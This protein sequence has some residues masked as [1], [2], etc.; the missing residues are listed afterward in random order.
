MSRTAKQMK[1]DNVM[2][3]LD[4]LMRKFYFSRDTITQAMEV[5]TPTQVSYLV[6][7]LENEME[8]RSVAR[9]S[10]MIK[11]AGFPSIK[12]LND[13]DFSHVSF[14]QLMGK[15]EVISLSFIEKKRTL[16]FYGICGSGKTMLATCLGLKACNEGYKV[17][18]MTVTH[19]VSRLTKAKED[20]YLERLL[21]EL[22]KLDLL[23][24]DEWGYCQISREASH[25]LFQV[26]AESYERKSLI[27][28]TNL[29]FSEW[30]KLMTDEQI[31]TAIIDRLVHYGHLI[32]TGPKDW[33]LEHSLMKDQ[34]VTAVRSGKGGKS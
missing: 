6:Q 29:P 19:L 30:G 16:V 23:I 1:H 22:G 25:L 9:V 5:G 10:R 27:V 34:I 20:G 21:M 7:L 28:T 4:R 8:R 24:L 14:P 32:D 31:A 17:R 11:G 13:Y 26:V 12:S 33:R 15:E 3:E 18:F 2:L